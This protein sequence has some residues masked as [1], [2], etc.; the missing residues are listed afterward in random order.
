MH[1]TVEEE[2]LICMYHKSDRRR[3]AANIRAAL[4][5]MDE[6]MAALARQ[7]ADKLERMTDADYDGIRYNKL[8]KFQNRRNENSPQNKG[9]GQR[10]LV[11]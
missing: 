5:G 9:Q 2:N 1:F 4:P 8:R 7:T 11:E 3:T 6:D 10:H